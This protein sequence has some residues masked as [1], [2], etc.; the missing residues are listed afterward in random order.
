MEDLN[1]FVSHTS[2]II[3]NINL[4]NEMGSKFGTYV[5]AV[6]Y[7]AWEAVEVEYITPK[8]EHGICLR[9]SHIPD[10]DK[11][12]FMHD[13]NMLN[14]FQQSIKSEIFQLLQYNG[15]CYSIWEALM[16][17]DRGNADMRKSKMNLIK[18]EF[19]IFN[20]VKGE[21]MPQM[22]ERY[23]HLVNEMKILGIN[24]EDFEYIDKLADTLPYDWS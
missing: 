3:Q 16:N 21:T 17:K 4:E 7:D 8:N 11:T 19:D 12:S 23:C 14:L 9:L 13:K 1:A 18:K 24:K 6:N 20:M 15:S 22:S 10:G 2:P 5:Q